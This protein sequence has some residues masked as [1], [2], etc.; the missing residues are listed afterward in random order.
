MWLDN[1]HTVFGQ[2]YERMEVVEKIAS[3]KT[4]NRDMPVEDVLINSIEIMA[5]GE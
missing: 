5:Y 4:N 3:V 2:D 1:K